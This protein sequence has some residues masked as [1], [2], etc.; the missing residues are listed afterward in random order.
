MIPA[1]YR[2]L[3]AEPGPRMLGQMLALYGTQE[4]AGA[5]DNPII[6]AWAEECGIH[7]YVHDSV[8][9]CGLCMAIAAKRSGWDYNPGHNALWARNWALWGARQAI[10]MLG[11]VLVF[12]RGDGGHVAMYVGEDDSHYHILGGNQGDQVSIARKPKTPILAIRRAPWRMS[13]PANVRIVRLKAAGA[14]L[15]TKET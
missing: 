12:P 2:W 15:S 14:P 4:A 5:A 13:Q 3:L 10:A 8:A 7:G 6:L 1:P 9:W 11:D